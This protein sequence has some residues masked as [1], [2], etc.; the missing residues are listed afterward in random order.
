[1]YGFCLVPEARDALAIQTPLLVEQAAEHNRAAR[2]ATYAF[3]DAAWGSQDW[4]SSCNCHPSTLRELRAYDLREGSIREPWHIDARY[5]AFFGS[6][7]TTLLTKIL[8]LVQHEPTHPLFKVASWSL[9][10]CASR[11]PHVAA[12]VQ[13]DG[14]VA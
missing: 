7:D 5:G 1:M 9:E 10:S 12:A 2:A 4:S 3:L 8:H 14:E 6:A 11:F 13:Q